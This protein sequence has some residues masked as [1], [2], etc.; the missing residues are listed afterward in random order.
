MIIG[1]F[2]NLSGNLTGTI[3]TLTFKVEAIFEP[4]EKTKDTAPDYRVTTGDTEIGAAWKER[5]EAGKDYLSV[6]LDGPA[7]PA[8]IKCALFK[9]G[10]EHGYSLVW[11]RPRRRS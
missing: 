10:A 5:S 4:L 7:L 11:D 2:K 3:K 8:P 9:I 6:Q 1:N